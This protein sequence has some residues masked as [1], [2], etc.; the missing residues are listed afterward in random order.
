VQ[1]FRPRRGRI[2]QLS[3]ACFV[4]I[5]SFVGWFCVSVL[6]WPGSLVC[7]PFD[8]DNAASRGGP[9]PLRP[10][11]TLTLATRA[12]RKNSLGQ[13]TELKQCRAM[14]TG[15]ACYF[16]QVRKRDWEVSF[17]RTGT[18]LAPKVRP[19]SSLWQRHRNAPRN[20]PDLGEVVE[21]NIRWHVSFGSPPLLVGFSSPSCSGLVR[22]F[23]ASSIGMMPLPAGA[24]PP[25]GLDLRFT[26][27]TRAA[28]QNSLVRTTELKQ[29]RALS[30]GQARYFGQVR[31]R[32][33]DMS[34]LFRAPKVRSIPA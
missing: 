23:V 8:C 1:R 20:V 11:P 32:D 3:L 25:C 18:L 29:C 2:T 27:A 10:R 26:L 33:W 15:Q 31:Q 21:P 16:G 22:A 9:S 30:T 5:A 6:L 7:C 17:L 4:W 19:Y 34:S 13:F 14:S 28:R 24:R 12:A